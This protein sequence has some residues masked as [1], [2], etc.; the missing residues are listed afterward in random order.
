MF[1]PKTYRCEM[2]ELKR[3]H[4]IILK[5][6]EPNENYVHLE[7]GN[8]NREMNLHESSSIT[9]LYFWQEIK[10]VHPG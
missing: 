3:R 4:L 8:A 9:L 10:Q 1:L 5:V 2:F 7:N 6:N